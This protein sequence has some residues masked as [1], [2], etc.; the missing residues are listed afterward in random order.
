METGWCRNVKQKTL[1]E[2]ILNVLVSFTST[3]GII[4]PILYFPPNCT[5]SFI[6]FISRYL[7][8]LEVAK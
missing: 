7:S 3:V 4:P 5:F 6:L 8:V 1:A 2:N